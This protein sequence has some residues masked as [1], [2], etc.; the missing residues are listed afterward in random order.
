MKERVK[1]WLAGIA[2]RVIVLFTLGKISPLLGAGIVIEQDGKVLMIERADGRGYTVP[3]GIVRAKETV[4]HCVVRETYE[5]TGYQV[6]ITGLVGIYSSPGRDPRFRSVSIVYKGALLGG[7]LRASQ[8][9]KP[10]WRAPA[11]VSGHL[12]FD[13]EA[14]L[15]DYLS[16]QQRL[17]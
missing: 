15:Q 17:F 10:C 5:E 4:E 14:V 9:G 8:E 16:G 1:G 13:S 2:Y 12:A 6:Q 7:S 11:E 3:G